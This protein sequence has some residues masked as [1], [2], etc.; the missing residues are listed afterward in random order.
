[1]CMSVCSLTFTCIY[2]ISAFL[3]YRKKLRLSLKILFKN[4]EIKKNVVNILY[5]KKRTNI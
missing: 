3:K 4:G 5:E 2:K 1:M